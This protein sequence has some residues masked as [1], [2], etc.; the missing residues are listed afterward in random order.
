MGDKGINQNLKKKIYSYKKAIEIL[1]EEF[2]EFTIKKYSTKEFFGLYREFFYDVDLN[3]LKTIYQQSK[4]IIG[5]YINPKEAIKKDLEEE[6]KRIQQQI[7]RT[8][9]HHP[10]FKNGLIMMDKIYDNYG[11]KTQISAPRFYI[12]SGKKRRIIWDYNIWKNIKQRL[13]L[14]QKSDYDSSIFLEQNAL[15][16]IPTGPPIQKID[17]LFKSIY[18]V[19]IYI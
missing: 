16:N 13:G 18:E 9:N 19:N 3:D 4:F 2:T 11:S 7:L 1:D 14:I 6:I 12:H 8:E 17:D 10:Y 15:E 5:G